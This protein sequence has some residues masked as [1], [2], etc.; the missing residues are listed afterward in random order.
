MRDTSG[1]LWRALR[2]SDPLIAVLYPHSGYLQDLQDEIPLLAPD[3]GL[4]RR[5]CDVADAFTHFEEVLLLTPTDEPTALSVLD[6]RREA[7][8]DRTAP[9]VL[10]L[11]RGGEATKLLRSED[12]AGLMSWLR[13][14]ILDPEAI[15]R[16]DLQAKRDQFVVATGKSPDVWLKE[17]REGELEDSLDNNLLYHQALLVAEDGR[18]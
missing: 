11:L 10:F 1:F 4:V 3:P 7:L 18:P 5:S 14:R 16:V 6:G 12:M 13:G 8:L 15:D 9:V 2:E 17:W